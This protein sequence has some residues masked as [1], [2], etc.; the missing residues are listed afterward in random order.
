M[1]H[2]EDSPSIIVDDEDD[3]FPV[4]LRGDYR[5]PRSCTL[6]FEFMGTPPIAE[7]PGPKQHPSNLLVP[8]VSNRGW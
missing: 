7:A 1:N 6:P 4:G 8:S 3:V 2:D 5:K